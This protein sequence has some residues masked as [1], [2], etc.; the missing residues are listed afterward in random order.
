MQTLQELLRARIA[1]DARA[2][3]GAITERNGEVRI[4]FGALGPLPRIVIAIVGSHVRVVEPAVGDGAELVLDANP[5]TFPERIV[6]DD[7]TREELIWMAQDKVVEI[8]TNATKAEI[9]AALNRAAGFE[10]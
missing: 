4:T 2:H 9:A 10:D 6:P 1:A 7:H 5:K 3:V 8:K